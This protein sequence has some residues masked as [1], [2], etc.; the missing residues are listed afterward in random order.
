MLASAHSN[1]IIV[2]DVH[3]KLNYSFP[4]LVAL[5]TLNNYKFVFLTGKLQQDNPKTDKK[6][7]EQLNNILTEKIIVSTATQ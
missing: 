1:G 6:N 5:R 4:D 2:I 3:T 7:K